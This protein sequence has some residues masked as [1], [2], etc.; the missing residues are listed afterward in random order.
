MMG[1]LSLIDSWWYIYCPFLFFFFFSD[2]QL[3]CFDIF[4]NIYISHCS[5][6]LF[7]PWYLP[8][9][10]RNVLMPADREI[11][12]R[13]GFCPLWKR[14]PPSPLTCSPC[15]NFQCWWGWL[16]AFLLNLLKLCMCA[17]KNIHVFPGWRSGVFFRFSE[18]F[19]TYKNLKTTAIE[20]HFCLYA[21]IL[22]SN[23]FRGLGY[24][25]LSYINWSLGTFR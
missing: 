17:H 25:N 14:A 24:F 18:G 12:L 3:A 8:K 4:K 1:N 9:I 21:W 7:V 5:F 23:K 20:L 22:K 13:A 19:M 2:L 15:V 10:L 11:E 6:Y 16:W